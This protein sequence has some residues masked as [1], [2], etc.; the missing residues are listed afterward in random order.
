MARRPFFRR[1][2]ML[3][4]RGGSS[5]RTGVVS[6]AVGGPRPGRCRLPSG[7]RAKP[8]LA[9]TV[10]VRDATRPERF[11]VLASLRSLSSTAELVRRSVVSASSQV[12]RPGDVIS[13]I[14]SVDIG[15]LLSGVG[16]LLLAF[17]RLPCGEGFSHFPDG[18]AAMPHPLRI[19]GQPD[20]AVAPCASCIA[21]AGGCVPKHQPASRPARGSSARLVQLHGTRSKTSGRPF[22]DSRREVAFLRQTLAS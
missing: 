12:W 4:A 6:A 13:L 9:G 18:P 2:R 7:V 22:C 3:A 14:R 11:P 15:G 21:I 10:G 5:S 16:V 17:C 8:N 1:P 19:D 20:S